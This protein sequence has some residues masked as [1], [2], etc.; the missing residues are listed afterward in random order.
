MNAEQ[1]LHMA[2]TDVVLERFDRA[3]PAIRRQIMAQCFSERAW[4]AEAL[5]ELVKL[6]SHHANLLNDYD[7]GKRTC[8]RSAQEW[9]DRLAELKKIP[10]G[11]K[12]R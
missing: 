10:P 8:F 12:V 2:A 3:N 9:L 6:Q 1:I 11:V 7:G 5:K 4:L